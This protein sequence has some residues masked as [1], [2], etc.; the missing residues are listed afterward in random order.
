MMDGYGMGY[1]F[2]GIF[3]LLWWVLSM[4]AASRW[5]F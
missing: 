5:I 3:M 2:G 1:G 4:V